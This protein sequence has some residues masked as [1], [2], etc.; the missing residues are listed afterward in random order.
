MGNIIKDGSKPSP[1]QAPQV[2]MAHP[3]GKTSD[4]SF[5][6]FMDLS[7]KE[8][9]ELKKHL[10]LD[11]KEAECVSMML[12][13]LREVAKPGE[14]HKNVIY[15]NADVLPGPALRGEVPIPPDLFLERCLAFIGETGTNNLCAFS[16][17]WRTDCRSFFG[18]NDED[19][20]AMKELILRYELPD[21]C[22][23]VV[24][25]ANA[26][27][28]A[29][30]VGVLDNLLETIPSCQLLIWTGTGEVA[31]SNKL[32]R[33]LQRHFESIGCKDQVGF[34]CK[35]RLGLFESNIVN[36]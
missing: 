1:S 24:L 20:K 19:A 8:N 4:L 15:L 14:A 27:V 9:K 23:G 12:D 30:N 21:K 2:I 28:L 35:V 26:R 5:R 11:I 34:D 36:Y 25:A 18:Y 31:I 32:F 13:T 29:R 16:L 3:P 33:H 7:I 6:N 22:L 10:K 17:G